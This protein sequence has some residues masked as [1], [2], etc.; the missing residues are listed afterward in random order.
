MPA[1]AKRSAKRSARRPAPIERSR[2]VAAEAAELRGALGDAVRDW[3]AV[4]RSQLRRRPYGTLAG[5]AFVGYVLGG[6]VPRGAMNAAL[7][8]GGRLAVS[9]L[10]KE[11]VGAVRSG[12]G[13]AGAQSIDEGD[14][15]SP[16]ELEE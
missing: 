14:T 7:L 11:V 6:G 15:D 3:Q 10:V 12:N 13:R 16:T 4:A 9:A 8:L 2:V 1:Q 5:A